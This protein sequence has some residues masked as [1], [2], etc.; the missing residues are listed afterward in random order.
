MRQTR[1]GSSIGAT[2]LTVLALGVF[3]LDPA[4]AAAARKARPGITVVDLNLLHG[5]FCPTATNQCDAPDRVALLADDLEAAGCPQVVGLQEIS[6]PLYDLL[7]R[8]ART[9]CHGDYR[10]VF[11]PPTGIDTELVLTR[12]PVTGQSVEKLFGGFRTA[13]RVSLESD[14]GPVVLVV[15]HQDG[16]PAT[17]QSAPC[18]D[19]CPPVCPSSTPAFECQTVAAAKLADGKDD[20]GALR[21]L[22][23]D[24]NVTPASAR[25]QHL[26]QGGWLDAYF[27]AGNPECDPATGEGCTSGRDDKSLASL[28]DPTNRETE[29]IDF[30]F[31]KPPAGCQPRFDPAEDAN[32]N[33][34]GTG[35]FAGTPAVA[36]PGGL[37]WPSDHIGVS[38][39]MSCRRTPKKG[40]TT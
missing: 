36:G 16:D 27:D 33:R 25:Y 22:M 19:H 5:A 14:L 26:V 24:F 34:I 35:L 7:R 39:D 31:V 1:L 4:T 20:K 15:T 29:R 3:T 18:A 13:S 40:S 6:R 9:L 21:I 12:L 28:Q 2:M 37:A 11:G 38:M 17:G 23:G 32:G 30:V 10:L 8:T